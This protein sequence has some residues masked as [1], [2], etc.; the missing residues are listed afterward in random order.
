MAKVTLGARGTAAAATAWERYAQIDQ[1]ARW[2]P[3]ITRVEPSA[4]RIAAGVTGR[5]FGPLG[6]SADF[7]IDS[8]DED[9]RRWA[10]TVRRRPLTVHLQHGVRSDG[11]GCRT[12]LT[13]DAPLPIVL[14]Y[15]LIAQLALRRLV[16]R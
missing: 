1:W 15:P 13:V 7:V 12:W 8:V 4:E 10:W 16:A 3:Q 11:D 6:V 14:A 9:A 2:A 5:V